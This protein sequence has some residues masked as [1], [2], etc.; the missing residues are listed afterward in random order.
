MTQTY[1]SRRPRRTWL[2]SSFVAAVAVLAPGL[3][4]S[5]A[6]A[7]AENTHHA[8]LMN[9]PAAANA[10]S[11]AVADWRSLQQPAGGPYFGK[12]DPEAQYY[13]TI[14]NTGDGREDVAYRWRFENRYRNPNTF[15]HAVPSVNSVTGPNVNSIESYDLYQSLV[16]SSTRS[17][18]DPL[19]TPDDVGPKTRSN[20]ADVS[21][22]A[23]RNVPGGAKTFVGPVDDPFFVDLGAVFDGVNIDKPGRPMI[24]LGNQGGGKDDVSG[25]GVHG[26]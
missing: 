5:R 11:P 14:D 19:C 2:G 4:S 13:A 21:H 8:H 6:V 9:D 18:S 22:R 12:L 15:L 25:V 3:I 16:R 23:I 26:F 10:A 24:G 20:A 1:R 7:T 17:T